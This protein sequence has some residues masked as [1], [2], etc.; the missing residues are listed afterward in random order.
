MKKILTGLAV[1]AAFL[2]ALFLYIV[3]PTRLKIDRYMEISE[4]RTDILRADAEIQL[5]DVKLDLIERDLKRMNS[6]VEQSI[7]IARYFYGAQGR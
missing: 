1:Y 6:N 4:I 7:A 2:A 5:V 3:L